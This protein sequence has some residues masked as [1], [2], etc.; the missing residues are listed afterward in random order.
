MACKGVLRETALW[1]S[2]QRRRQ[3]SRTDPKDWKNW[4]RRR[5]PARDCLERRRARRLKRDQKRL[6][7]VVFNLSAN[8]I[9]GDLTRLPIESM[10]ELR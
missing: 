4:M 7:C 6:L 10:D 9:L 3:A 1:E 8:F 5:E 2:G